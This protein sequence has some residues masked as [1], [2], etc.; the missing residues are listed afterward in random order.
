MTADSLLP[1]TSVSTLSLFKFFRFSES[2]SFKLLE[3]GASS[4][5]T[6]SRYFW[7]MIFMAFLSPARSTY[8]LM[9]SIIS[10]VSSSLWKKLKVSLRSLSFSWSEVMRAAAQLDLS[11]GRG[12]P[13]I[14]QNTN[15]F[16]ISRMLL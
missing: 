12:M 1:V 4:S 13:P 3:T 5:S 15:S 8:G 9:N 11:S 7:F 6:T 10:A 2:V 16:L 14:S